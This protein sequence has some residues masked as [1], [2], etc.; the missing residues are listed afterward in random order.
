MATTPPVTT[1]IDT[2]PTP[3]HAGEASRHYTTRKSTRHILTR[4]TRA[5]ETPPLD[6]EVHHEPP[7]KHRKVSPHSSAIQPHSP[8]SSTHTSPRKNLRKD[9]RPINTSDMDE[10]GS[11]VDVRSHELSHNSGNSGS[12]KDIPPNLDPAHALPTPASIPRKKAIPQGT[13]NAAA[14][15]LFPSQPDTV[16][17]AM[18]VPRKHHRNRRHVNFSLYG[19]MEDGGQ[20]PADQIQVY[21]DS[22]EKVPELDAS[23]DN[24]FFQQP[25]KAAPPPEPIK[26]RTN[27]KRKQ[28]QRVES[29]PQIEEAFNR[30]EGMVYVFRGKKMYR[31]FPQGSDSEPEVTP[32]AAILDATNINDPETSNF[33]PLTR[34]S[35]KPRLLFP[36]PQQHNER[37]AAALEAEEASTDIEDHHVAQPEKVVTPVKKSF[38]PATPP[39]TGHATRST[40]KK[41][42]DATMSPLGIEEAGIELP[43]EKRKKVSPF[44]GWART[45]A[46][47]EAGGKRRKRE[48]DEMERQEGLTGGKRARSGV[49]S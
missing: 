42:R 1:V 27:R 10:Q 32:T 30:E 21:T 22:K 43:A 24:P 9:K 17:D 20:S 2:P 47:V 5:T 23:E 3:R 8:P 18:P 4:T 34:S 40:T 49:S 28:S 37:D 26:A 16:E 33:R 31:K 35:I 12:V 38:T 7:A 29:N 25:Q 11:I 36:T 41:A 14:R 48:A 39:M 45:K 15:V 6:D 13:A 44:D 46:G 19:S